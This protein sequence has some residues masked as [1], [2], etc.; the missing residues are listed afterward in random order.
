M[1]ST[2]DERM[3]D[4]FELRSWGEDRESAALRLGI[5]TRTAER[6][7]RELR[8]RQEGRAGMSEEDRENERE[9]AVA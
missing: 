2:K 9:D 6:Y 3:T 4:Y 7:E 5:S 8:R 1:T